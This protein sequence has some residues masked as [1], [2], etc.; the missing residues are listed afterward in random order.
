VAHASALQ[1]NSTFNALAFIRREG[2]R[3]L[4]GSSDHAQ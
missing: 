4:A 1:A 3:D 2:F